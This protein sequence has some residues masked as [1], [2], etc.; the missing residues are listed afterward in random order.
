M[1]KELGIKTGFPGESVFHDHAAFN[2]PCLCPALIPLSYKFVLFFFGNTET[3]QACQQGLNY[4]FRDCHYCLLSPEFANSLSPTDPASCHTPSLHF[5]YTILIL[6]ANLWSVMVIFP[7]WIGKLRPKRRS[8]VPRS[9]TYYCQV[10]S[11]RCFLPQT[12]RSSW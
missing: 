7:L 11:S 8:H 9:R 12:R 1:P 4:N 2:P 10:P 5:M 6:S 3:G